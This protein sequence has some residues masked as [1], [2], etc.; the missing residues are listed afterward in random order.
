M[1]KFRKRLL[2][3]N[4]KIFKLFNL[5]M[6]LHFFAPVLVLFYLENNLSLT[7]VMIL[8]AIFS[9]CV[10]ALEVPSGYVADLFGRRKTLIFG[11][12]AFF[13][14]ISV[15][16]TG[17]TFLVFLIGEIL[18]AFGMSFISG[19]DSAILY[20]TLKDL[21]RSDEFKK[22]YGDARFYFLAAVSFASIVGGLIGSI[23]YRW[24][25][26]A[27][28]PFMFLK[29]PLAMLFTEPKRHKMIVER[30]Y[31]RELF[32]V[33]RENA[34]KNRKVRW[35]I[36]YSGIVLTFTF[37]SF[38]LSQPYLQ[39]SGITVVYIGVI[40]AAYNLFAAVV[41][42]YAHRIEER[43]GRRST[44]IVLFVFL[45][46]GFLLMGNIVFLFSFS[47]MFLHQFVRAMA[48]II[49]NDY[50][51]RYTKSSI[52]ATVL[53]IKSLVERLLYAIVLPVFGYLAD[54]Y[55]IVYAM[56]I[57]GFAVLC[58]GIIILLILH[59]DKVM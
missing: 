46:A 21:G 33:I 45:G 17:R 9:I 23:S 30:G 3:R 4:I 2:E 7:Q 57:A 49:L 20:D 42:R 39:L 40:F 56:A 12:F 22:I 43:I 53:S 59:K 52:R 50:V 6:G 31:L 18:W 37:V 32:F 38:W 55:S 8:Q 29:A 28:I 48:R 51:N 1:K 13:V 10:A 15:Y 47:F 36:V 24:A 44:L 11:G 34:L 25:F 41:S 16:S 5:V 26:Y 27:M 58:F 19:A 35:L 54:L 14:S